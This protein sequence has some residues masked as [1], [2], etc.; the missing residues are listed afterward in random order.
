MERKLAAIFSADVK[1][2]R[3]LK[4]AFTLAQKAVALEARA[5]VAEL[6]RINPNFSL[7]LWVQRVHFKDQTKSERYVNALRKAGLTFHTLPGFR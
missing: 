2:Y 6:L 5:T 1:G 3:R 7:E 4:Q